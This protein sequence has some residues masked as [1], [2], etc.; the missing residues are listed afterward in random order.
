MSEESSNFENTHSDRSSENQAEKKS[1]TSK[2]KITKAK[3]QTMT[4]EIGDLTDHGDREF[5]TKA[6][7]A[8]DKKFISQN[9]ESLL[10]LLEEVLKSF[11]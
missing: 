10:C 5:K 6:D 2:P 4:L 8:D 1:S 7:N 11:K 9:S 3:P